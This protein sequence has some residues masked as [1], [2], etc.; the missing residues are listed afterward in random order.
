MDEKSTISV[1][2]TS[3][4]RPK[5][6]WLRFVVELLYNKLS[7][8]STTNQSKRS[9]G[10]II[11]GSGADWPKANGPLRQKLR[12]V[13]LYQGENARASFISLSAPEQ[14]ADGSKQLRV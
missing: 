4:F 1:Q 11:P 2:W 13:D 7:N 14:A 6:H 9:L 12:K 3:S 5:F 8:K 10:F